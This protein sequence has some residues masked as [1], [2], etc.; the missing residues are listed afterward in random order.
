MRKMLDLSKLNLP[1]KQKNILSTA[2]DL[3][4]QFGIKRISIEEIC[5]TA[6]VSKM[7]FYKYFKN[8]SE[9]VRF[10][11]TQ[12]YKQ[13]FEKFDAIIAMDIP[14]E[15]KL[16]KLLKLK[17]ETSAKISHEFALDYFYGS[18]DLREFFE[19]LLREGMSRFLK[20]IEKSQEKGEVR[21]D[22]KPEF[23]LAILNHIKLMVKEEQLINLYPDYHDFVMEVNHFIFY[24]ILPRPGS[25][26]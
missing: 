15:E 25:K 24:G 8:K 16:Q 6:S 26:T 19:S 20:F 14:F 4:Q 2:L 23:L 9:L 22:L 18:D 10:M 11:W 13:A 1:E 7:T 12:G 17:D 3:F 21:R 5:K